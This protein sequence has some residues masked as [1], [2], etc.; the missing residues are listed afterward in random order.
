M[1]RI[2]YPSRNHRRPGL[3]P[4]RSRRPKMPR[5]IYPTR[6]HRRPGLYPG[7]S[8]RARSFQLNDTRFS[9]GTFECISI[10][11][12]YPTTTRLANHVMTSTPQ[13]GPSND[14]ILRG[15]APQLAG[16]NCQ[17]PVH[18]RP[19]LYPGR[20]RRARSF[21]L[22]APRVAA[23]TCERISLHRR[24]PTT[25]QL[26]NHVMTSTPQCGPSNDLIL[27]GRAPQ[28]AGNS[29]PKP[30]HRRPGLYPGRSRRARSFQLNR[31]RVAAGTCER[32][33]IHRCHPTTTRVA[34]HVISTTTQRDPS[35]DLMLRRRAPQ[36]AG[37]SCPKPVHRRPGL[38]PGRS[39]R[40]RSFQL[41]RTRVAAGTC[42]RI[43]LHRR[44]PTTTQL[45]N[46]V[47]TSTPQ[48][49]PSNDLILRGRHH[50]W[51]ATTA[52][53]PSTV[54]RDCIPA[55]QGARGPSNSPP[56]GSPPAPANASRSIAAALRQ[57]SWLITS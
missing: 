6:N 35:N 55:G 3:Y 7:R 52:R 49:G 24:C 30:V 45:A 36:M 33:S 1:P 46:H 56:Q 5:I 29:C 15:R 31:T 48:C 26:A 18:R 12:C 8:T 14:L 38:Y 42:E 43:S 25:T 9:A 27:R 28:L 51:P 13:C 10:H 53:N 54:G 16:N 11:R 41:N 19:G 34:N 21:Q 39:R 22:T 44:C 32:S 50:N 2:N 17:K 57:L 20:S 47:M 40:A 23:G 4:G 37:N